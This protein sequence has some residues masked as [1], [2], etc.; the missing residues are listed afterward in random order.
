MR[1]R[2]IFDFFQQKDTSDCNDGE[3]V[4]LVC[5][6]PPPF[7][8]CAPYMQ[9]NYLHPPK[10]LPQYFVISK[11]LPYLCRRKKQKNCCKKSRKTDARKVEKLLQE[12]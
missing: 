8:S 9:K 10:F 7:H 12:K 3:R 1:G 11:Y 4:M 5:S 2:G 6:A